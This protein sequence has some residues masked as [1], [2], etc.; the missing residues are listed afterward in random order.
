MKPGIYTFSLPIKRPFRWRALWILV[1]LL[2]LANLA[3]IPLL[4]ATNAPI[5][6]VWQW[7][8][9]TA[10]TAVLIGLG[11]YLG[12][13]IGLGAPLIEGLL[14]RDEIGVGRDRDA[15]S[16]DVVFRVAGKPCQQNKRR[17]P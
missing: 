7:G 11:L 12:S 9:Y 5:E 2:I 14:G 6:P 16:A 10:V 4:R 17:A 13:R 1:V 15:H 8:V 3:A